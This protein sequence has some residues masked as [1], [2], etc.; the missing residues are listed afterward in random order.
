MKKIIFRLIF[1]Y[2]VFGGVMGSLMACGNI[3][4]DATYMGKKYKIDAGGLSF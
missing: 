3:E 4:N 1:M 2:L